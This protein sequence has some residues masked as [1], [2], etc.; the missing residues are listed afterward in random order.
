MSRP[1]G[2]CVIGVGE[3]S[4][5]DL[6]AHIEDCD[7]DRADL[8]LHVSDQRIDALVFD[9]IDGLAARRAAFG[10]IL[11]HQSVEPYLVAAA[12]QAG[13]VALA[14]EAFG[15]IA[16]DTGAGDEDQTDGLCH[17]GVPCSGGSTADG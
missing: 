17:G 11:S 10:L 16:A 7:F 1:T 8:G 5:A 3:T 2:S 4:V 9:R 14:G 13:V 6:G 15:E 12:S